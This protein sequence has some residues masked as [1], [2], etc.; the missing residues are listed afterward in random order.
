MK[1]IGEYFKYERHRKKLSF[2][3]IEEKTKIKKDFIQS[4]ENEKWSNL[5]EYPVVLGFVKS[6]AGILEID[7]DKAAAF[8]RRDY[9]PK[10]IP[11]NPKPDVSKEFVWSP[12]LTFLVSISVIALLAFAY[13]T[14]Q[15]R[16]FVSPP[17][18]VVDLPRNEQEVDLPN[19][20]VRGRTDVDAVVTANNQP[21]IVD[22]DGNFS[23][24]L[25]INQQTNEIVIIAK[26]RSGKETTISR[27]INP[28]KEL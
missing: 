16:K 23:F 15:Y 20:L 11:I 13:L 28:R 12:K 4:I 21:V 7:P 1:T 17:K 25:E 3:D 8:L 27:K 14:I 22:S 2:L 18:L 5:P 24:D 6:I 26:S 9:P 19:V 10:V